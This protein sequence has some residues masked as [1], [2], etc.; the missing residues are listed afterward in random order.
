MTPVERT[1][2]ISKVIEEVSAAYCRRVWWADQIDL[3]QD[4]WVEVLSSLERKPVPDEWLKGTVYRICSRRISQY[5]WEQ[6][7]PA[8]GRRG[9][10]HFQGLKRAS[11]DVHLASVAGSVAPDSRALTAEA[12]HELESA[13]ERLFWRIAELYSEALA[14][15]GQQ[16]RGLLL[17]AVMRV[18]LDG[19]P[20]IEAARACEAPLAEVYSE[21]ARV[22]KLIVED[23]TAAELLEEIAEWRGEL[24]E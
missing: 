1:A 14:S 16:A 15:T 8:T 22:K 20:S 10:R 7:S 2:A 11:A 21:T 13:R 23:A 19:Q 9:G 5:L 12:E 24:S 3:M 17:E 18:L 6:S 4:A